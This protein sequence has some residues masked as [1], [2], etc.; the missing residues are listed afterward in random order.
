MLGVAVGYIV[1]RVKLSRKNEWRKNQA[2]V[3]SVMGF[4]REID[5]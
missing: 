4:E 2:E 1:E 5:A 3:E